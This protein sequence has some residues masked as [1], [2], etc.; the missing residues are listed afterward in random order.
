MKPRGRVLYLVRESL[1]APISH[2][3]GLE[4]TVALSAE[5]PFSVISFEPWRRGRSANDAAEYERVRQRLLAHDVA[6]WP[7]PVVGT[8][9][10]EIPMGATA[11]LASVV[12]GGTRVVHARSYFPGIMAML[13]RPLVNARFLFDMRG[14]FVDEYL[15]EGAFEPGTAR[16]RFARWLERRLLRRADAIVV[17]SER[18]RDHLME[19]SDLD[20]VLDPDKITVIPNRVDLRRFK[21]PLDRREAAR[22]RRGWNG[23]LVFAYA[24][25]SAKW[26]RLDRTVELVA[27]VLGAMPEARFAAT[28]YPNPEALRRMALAEGIPPGRMDLTTSPVEEVPGFLAAADVGL[29]LI[30]D[31]ISKQVCAPIKFS[32]YM[33]AGLPV[34]AGGGI[35]DTRDW[36]DQHSL[37]ILVDPD[38]PAGAAEAVATAAAQG[39]LR[40]DSARRRCLTFAADRLDMRDTLSDYETIYRTLE[41]R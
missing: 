19:R 18:F 6:H 21:G 15:L 2:L 26:H 13:V 40:S 10:L 12:F 1:T 22:A 34:V 23:S 32:E 16:L 35:G 17:V 38:D 31:D 29:M 8:R 30:D 3:H 9:W 14:L 28:V 27:R 11:V 7:M 39:D 37:G 4:Q 5:R 24:G 41:R 20:R 25:S 33:A 36:I